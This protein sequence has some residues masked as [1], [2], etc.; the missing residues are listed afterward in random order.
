MIPIDVLSDPICPWCYIGKARLDRARAARPNLAL[1]LH[2]QP[3]QLNPD[4]PRAGMDRR[5]YLEAKFG[6]KEGAARVYVQIETVAQ[7]EGLDIDFA[8]IARTPNTLDAHRLIRWAEIEGCQDSVVTAL[9]QRYFR[10]GQDISDP[11]ILIET[12]EEAGMEAAMV[13]QLLGTDADLAEVRAAD[14]RAREMGVSGVPTFLV[15]HQYVLPGAQ[16]TAVWL[17]AFDE[18]ESLIAAD[19]AET[20]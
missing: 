12:A 10:G 5:A 7:A 2:W 6:G 13:A 17:R 3:F 16:E 9:F 20:P 19:A 1:T 14:A 8:A 15:A 11:A 4:M 18:I